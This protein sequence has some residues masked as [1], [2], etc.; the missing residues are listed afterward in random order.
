MILIHHFLHILNDCKKEL[1]ERPLKIYYYYFKKK[2]CA[3]LLKFSKPK[4][5][6]LPNAE[7]CSHCKTFIGQFFFYFSL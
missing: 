7:K 4:S 1:S 5:K 3:F 2:S 6:I